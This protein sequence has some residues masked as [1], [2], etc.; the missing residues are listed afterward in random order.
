MPRVIWQLWLWKVKQRLL[1]QPFCFEML[2][3]SQGRAFRCSQQQCKHREIKKEMAKDFQ[4]ICVQE[5]NRFSRIHASSI[6]YKPPASRNVQVQRQ[7]YQMFKKHCVRN[8]A[9]RSLHISSS[10]LS[11]CRCG[12]LAR[13]PTSR[14][15]IVSR[16]AKKGLPES[17]RCRPPHIFC[18]FRS[19]IFFQHPQW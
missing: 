1:N 5:R 6:L 4:H 17:L 7:F 3:N 11:V 13:F 19:P 14:T 15:S 9:P 8:V 18:S 10:L 2:S 12:M 16:L